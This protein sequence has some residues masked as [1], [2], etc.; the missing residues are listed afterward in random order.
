M[1]HNFS[2]NILG[3]IYLLLTP[4]ILYAQLDFEI[5]RSTKESRWGIIK[6]TI[7]SIDDDAT[8]ILIRPFQ[9]P[10]FEQNTATLLS[11]VLTDY[12]TTKFFQTC[13]E[14]LDRFLNP[15]VS[16]PT[17]LNQTPFL[18]R[19]TT[20]KDG[21]IYFGFTA[22]YGA[23]LLSGNEKLQEASLLTTKAI[24]ES[25][26]VSHLILKTLIARHR[27]ARPLWNF[28]ETDRDSQYPFVHTPFDFFNFHLPVLGSNPYGTGFPSYHA[29]MYFSIASV[30][31]RVYNNRWLPYGIMTLGMMHSIRGHNHWVSE[32]VAGYV[33]GNFIGK[34]VYENYHEQRS[35]RNT[36]KLKKKFRTTVF[37][38]QTFGVLGPSLTISW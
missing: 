5:D 25:Y 28:T 2:R 30:M 17:I 31:S 32:L 8:D 27:P 29:T 16:F 22:L 9:N 14:P 7:L 34:V 13:I 33:I 1:K 12:A 20:G 10:K 19:A 11:L 6:N 18:R 21:Y 23:G 4:S 37:V 24:I 38:G 35:L 3:L 36:T 26:V 15:Y